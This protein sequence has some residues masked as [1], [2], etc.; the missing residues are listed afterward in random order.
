MRQ[1]AALEEAKAIVVIREAYNRIVVSQR[2]DIGMLNLL[3]MSVIFIYMN[4]SFI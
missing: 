4:I 1:I 3:F 2:N